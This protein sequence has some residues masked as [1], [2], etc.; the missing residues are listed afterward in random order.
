MIY[1]LQVPKQLAI[2][3][4]LAFDPYN[5]NSNFPLL[6]EMPFAA[7]MVL[8]LPIPPFVV[9]IAFAALLILVFHRAVAHRARLSPAENFAVSLALATTPVLFGL[10]HTA[11]AEIFFAL[12][13]LLAA[14]FYLRHLESESKA[15]W[16]RACVCLGFSCAVKYPGAIFAALFFAHA[17]FRFRDRKSFYAGV[18]LCVAAGFPWYLKNWILTGNPVYPLANQL[19][20]SPYMS[21]LRFQGFHHMLVDYNMGRRPID[22]LLLPFRLALGQDSPTS[23]GL[24][25]D[26]RLSLLFAVGLAGLGWK[27]ADKR[28]LT[29]IAAGYFAVWAVESQQTRFLLA[30]VPI[31]VVFGLRKAG[32]LPMRA[33]WIHTGAA[34]ILAQNAFGIAA[35]LGADGIPDLLRGKVDANAFLS[36]RMPVSYR[37]AGEI[38]A[39]M[40]ASRGRLMT[41]GTFGR[42]YYF[43]APTLSNTYYEQEVFR[44]TFSRGR[45]N[46]DSLAG[47]LRNSGVTHIL[48]NWDYVMKM[49]GRDAEFDVDGLREYLSRTCSAEPFGNGGIV[50][51][52]RNPEGG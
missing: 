15:D 38:N 46:P 45:A 25:F 18:L 19:F 43:K 31:A 23:G 4:R 26:G 44:M 49:N 41:V 52:R 37:L 8:R 28:F 30:I 34:I 39:R 17:F 35:T 51:Y 16:L 32:A 14:L 22:Y 20:G 47:F 42:N 33:W 48:F 21:A 1:H 50:L 9:N 7:L 36:A 13:I 2:T 11:Y 29:L 12:I 10:L 27:G 40:D 3:G 6:F 24:G 5:V